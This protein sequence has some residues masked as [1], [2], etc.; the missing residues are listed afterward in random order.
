MGDTLEALTRSCARFEEALLLPLLN[1]MLE[2][3]MPSIKVRNALAFKL[4]DQYKSPPEYYECP[5]KSSILQAWEKACGPHWAIITQIP[6]IPP[7]ESWHEVEWDVNKQ[8]IKYTLHPAVPVLTMGQA[9]TQYNYYKTESVTDTAPS[10]SP[11]IRDY[12]FTSRSPEGKLIERLH[13]VTDLVDLV[14]VQQQLR[15][16]HVIIEITLKGEETS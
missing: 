2:L 6:G 1:R 5:N 8:V 13:S 15:S 14:R 12:L 16:D 3:A 10:P 9:S 7:G 11:P 4:Q